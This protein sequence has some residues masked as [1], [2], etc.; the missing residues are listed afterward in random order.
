MIIYNGAVMGQVLSYVPYL[1][2]LIVINVCIFS[3]DTKQIVKNLIFESMWKINAKIVAVGLFSISH[4]QVIF[5]S[6]QICF[7]ADIYIIF[8]SFQ[9]LLS[10]QFQDLFRTTKAPVKHQWNEHKLKLKIFKAKVLI[11]FCCGQLLSKVVIAC[12]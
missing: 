6:F 3:L 2:S 4:V 8:F 12:L 9:I 11:L 10:F 1:H 5:S 7:Y